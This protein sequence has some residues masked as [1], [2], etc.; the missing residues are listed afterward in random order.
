MGM[1]G[2]PRTCGVS[3]I[4]ASLFGTLPVPLNERRLPQGNDIPDLIVFN[5]VPSQLN[6]AGL[7]LEP[8]I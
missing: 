3:P 8:A 7:G 2:G 5:L 6:N 1:L 4:P